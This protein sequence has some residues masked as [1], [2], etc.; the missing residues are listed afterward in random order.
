MVIDNQWIKWKTGGGGMVYS[1][2]GP[3]L[4]LFAPQL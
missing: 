3:C 2:L 4:R 1:G